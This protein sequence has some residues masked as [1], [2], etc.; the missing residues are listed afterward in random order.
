M[1]G[2]KKV[3]SFS[4]SSS[5][6]RNWK[7]A[8]F[9]FLAVFCIL[10]LFINAYLQRQ[11]FIHYVKK[12]L[13]YSFNSLSLSEW[14]IAYDNIQF[15]PFPLSHLVDIE[16][17]KIYNKVSKSA[18]VCERFYF[19]N[20]I[21]SPKKIKVYFGGKQFIKTIK[22]S[23]KLEIPQYE[24]NLTLGETQPQNLFVN[25]HNIKLTDWFSVENAFFEINWA[26]IL[27]E[28][29]TSLP[30]NFSAKLDIQNLKFN[31]LVDYPLGQNIK[32]ISMEAD[33]LGTPKNNDNFQASLRE[34]L[35]QDGFFRINNFTINWRPLLMVGKGEFYLNENFKPILTLDTTSKALLN[36][37]DDMEQR[38]WLDSK[39]VF[40]AKVLLNNKAYKIDEDKYLTISTPISIRDDAVLVE[41]IAIKKFN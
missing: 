34:W 4:L 38:H 40:V 41:K 15:N 28:N 33:M 13:E 22:S 7:W 9:S 10:T 16:N 23:H 21:L 19:D 17:L 29:V 24:I 30:I 2:L 8:F 6:F 3:S 12:N 25:L 14:D 35:A 27:T 32:N 26:S 20:S 36:L 11:A 31:G 39:G 18:W 37:L 5:V 1:F